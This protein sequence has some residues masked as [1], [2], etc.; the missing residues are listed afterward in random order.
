[1]TVLPT[2]GIPSATAPGSGGPFSGER[3]AEALTGVCAVAGLDPAGATLI[4]CTAN[5]VFR[6]AS[7][8]VV[9][10]IGAS[11]A[12]RHRVE[13]VVHVATW[14]AEHDVPAV[15]LLP[16]VPQPVQYDGYV[17]T[18]WE[19]VPSGGKRPR[20]RDLGKLLRRIHDL[21]QPASWL[22]EWR[23][24]ADVRARIGEADL[25]AADLAFLQDR[26]DD[27]ADQL[28]HL[29][30][31]SPPS[32]VHGDAHLGNLIASPAGPV[33]CDFDSS[34]YGPPEWDLT[35][36]AVGVVRFGEPA[37]RYRELVRTYGLDVTRWS[38]FAVLRAVR[39]LKLIT[40]VLPIIGSRPEV[41]AELFRRMADVRSGNTSARW[42]RY[43]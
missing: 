30:F 5:A 31:P 26:Y 10:R 19:A 1:M 21:P 6:L 43:T 11:T 14:L 18:I 40:S 34:S 13:K 17:A 27:V 9:V 38:G 32:L 4:K 25:D 23:P 7:A 42:A 8:P 24:L 33:L 29:D 15:R 16:G 20:G 12:L 37:G 35:P 39:E 41:S 2:S 22:P 3:L 36:L 28:S